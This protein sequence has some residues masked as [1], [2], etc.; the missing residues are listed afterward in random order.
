MKKVILTTVAIFTF[1]FVNAQDMSRSFDG[2]TSKG[3][4]LI[5]ANTGNA[6]LGNTGFYFTSSDG[7]SSYNIGFDGGARL[8]EIDR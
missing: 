7:D 4:W 6:M 8:I 3:K 2:Q 5:E 1:V